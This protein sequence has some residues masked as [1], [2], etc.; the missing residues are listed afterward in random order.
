MC[1]CFRFQ[2]ATN[3]LIFAYHSRDPSSPDDIPQHE[4]RGARSVMLLNAQKAPKLPDNLQYFDIVNNQVRKR[5][6]R[7]KN[8]KLTLWEWR[9]SI[10]LHDPGIQW[11]PK[12]TRMPSP[13]GIPV[14]PSFRFVAHAIVFSHFH[15]ALVILLAHSKRS[16]LIHRHVIVFFF[17]FFPRVRI[18]GAFSVQSVSHIVSHIFQ[19]K[20]PA[21]DTTY[22]CSAFKIPDFVTKHHIVKVTCNTAILVRITVY[23]LRLGYFCHRRYLFFSL[24]VFL[25]SLFSA[26]AIVVTVS[27][28]LSFLFVIATFIYFSSS[29]LMWF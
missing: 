27:S 5:V 17:F 26:V 10:H 28:L 12:S 14:D 20:L 22:W 19:S 16:E 1:A 9:D 8:G 24:F 23:H 29:T 4:V 7:V 15:E 11:N 18:D 3:K 25:L 21:N 6:R 2:E 13:M